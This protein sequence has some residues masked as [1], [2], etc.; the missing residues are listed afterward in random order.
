[1]ASKMRFQTKDDD[2]EVGFIEFNH[3]SSRPGGWFSRLWTPADGS[4]HDRWSERR[5]RS[6][7][8]P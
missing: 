3:L 7:S 2:P 4:V 5:E 1:M 6:L 8:A